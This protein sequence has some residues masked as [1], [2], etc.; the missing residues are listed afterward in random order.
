MDWRTLARAL[1]VMAAD[2]RN[3]FEPDRPVAVRVDHGVGEALLDLALIEAGVPTISMP[4][5]FTAMQTEA[6]LDHAGAPR[7]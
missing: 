7:W 1:P 5:F 6:A 4:S 2:L 3:R